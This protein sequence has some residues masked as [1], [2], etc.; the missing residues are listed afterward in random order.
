MSKTSSISPASLAG[1]WITSLVLL[2]LFFWLFSAML[3][4]FV[5]G[6]T[7]AYLLDPL[8]RWLEARK[9]GR[10]AAAVLLLTIFFVSVSLLLLLLI[11]PLYRELSQ[12]V[13]QAPGYLQVLADRV[14]PYLDT[15]EQ[16]LQDGAFDD[17][18]R[19]AVGSNVG[20]AINLGSGVLSGL[21]SGGRA[22]IGF[23]SLLVVT[24]LVAFF[25]M[26]E[27]R[28]IIGTIDGLIP[29][30]NYSEIR[31]LVVQIDR[32]ISGFVR[33]QLLVALSLGVIY[34]VALSFAGLDFSVLIGLG[35]GLLSII[36]LFGSIAG[37]LASVIVAWLQTSE[38]AYVALIAGIFMVGQLLEGNVIT[39][40]LLGGSVG[41]HPLW[42]LF[43]IMA[44]ASLLGILGMM[45][46]V[47]VAA[48][49]GVLLSFALQR[50]QKSEFYGPN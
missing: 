22:L 46:A 21:L 17:R 14:Q 27:W 18:V 38:F 28:R 31:E 39:P 34:A 24:P 25:M 49:V 30:H 41:M 40:K 36:P 45:I 32:K 15:V 48:A 7:I 37:L 44:G 23:L 16:Q 43:S 19:E 47:P 9:I 29:R 42:I 26:R 20:N 13:D 10:T 8:V 12:L 4:P 2:G 35:A 6:I 1:F 50:Y 11:P 33:G 5:L 3:T